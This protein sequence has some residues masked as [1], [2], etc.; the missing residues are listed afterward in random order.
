MPTPFYHLSVSKELL[1]HPGLEQAA[2]RVLE[3]SRGAFLFG[4]T[5]PDVQVVSGQS[6]QATHF[7]DVPIRD[8]NRLPWEQIFDQYPLLAA[9]SELPPAQAAFLAGYMCHL[10]ADWFW[11]V[12]IFGP[13]FGLRS[14]W[15]SFPERLYLHNVLRS[16]LDWEIAPAL[17]NG[18]GQ[19]LREAEPQAWLPFVQDRDLLTWRD[20][21][22]D[23]LV[24]GASIQTVEVFAARQ[25]ISPGDYYQMLESQ[26]KMDREIF[27][28]LPRGALDDYRDRL[29]EHNLHFLNTYLAGCAQA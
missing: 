24:P 17:Q 29:V 20:L 22:A 16:Y 11:V 19:S 15:A 1:L 8:R 25:G 3:N 13:V 27:S 2:R 7:F 9:A 14:S 4:N 21:L 5:A 12:E 10:Q 18:M 26:E 28:H 23:Q 6:R